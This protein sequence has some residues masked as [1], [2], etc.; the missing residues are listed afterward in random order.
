MVEAARQRRPRTKP[1]TVIAG[2]TRNL[3]P[4]PALARITTSNW[5]YHDSCGNLFWL[6]GAVAQL[7]ERLLCKQ[8][9]AGSIPAGS[10]LGRFA[11]LLSL[12]STF[13]LSFARAPCDSSPEQ[14]RKEC[15]PRLALVAQ[16]IE[17]RS[18]KAGVGGS[19]PLGRTLPN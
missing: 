12:A 6:D 13:V 10:T 11:T 4:A 15:L 9:V 17:H 18:P 2:L 16:G 1:I 8:E 19:N 7:V 14:S 5:G 3:A